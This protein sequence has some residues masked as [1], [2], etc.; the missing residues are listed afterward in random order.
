MILHLP[1]S[2]GLNWLQKRVTLSKA[3]AQI[4]EKIDA[5]ANS[6][7]KKSHKKAKKRYENFFGLHGT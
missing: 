4:V 3:V 1:Q 2:S 7:K 5:P 6:T